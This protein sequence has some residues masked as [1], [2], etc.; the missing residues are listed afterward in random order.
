MEL[1]P[2]Q[3]DAI[4]DLTTAAAHGRRRLLLCAF[5]GSGKT[6]IAASVIKTTVSSGL[7][8]LVLCPRREIVSQTLEKLHNIGVRA[9]MMMSG[10][11]Y[12]PSQ[13]V[14]V[15]SIQTLYSWGI[16]RKRES[17]PKA[18]L[19]VVD[20]CHALSGSE[21]WQRILACYPEAIVVGMSATPI[22]RAGKGLA[23]HFD[24]MICGP[25]CKEL[26][27]QGYLVPVRYYI[28]SIPD[29]R[30]LHV[31]Q[32][33][34]V[35]SELQELMDKPKLVGDVIE[36]WARICPNRQTMI[37]ASGI[38]HSQHLVEG[39]TKI[40]VKAIHIDG[41]TDVKIRDEAIKKFRAKEIQVICN[42]Q[43]Y[44]EGTDLPEIECIAFARP[45]KSLRFFLQ[46]G[47]RGLRTFPGKIDAYVLDF[48]GVLY[49]HGPIDQDWKWELEYNEG[50]ISE[51][52]RKETEK[53][54]KEGITCGSCKAYYEKKLEC[55]F[56]GWV[57]LAKGKPV[58]T[59]EGYLEA[60]SADELPKKE[61]KAIWWQGLA[62]Y[63]NSRGYSS[64]W[65]AHKY[66]KHFGVWPTW[67]V[68][69]L[70]L[71]EP[72]IE[73]KAFIQKEM[74]A[75]VQSKKSQEQAGRPL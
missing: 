31:R 58:K 19:V 6:L 16:K 26:T 54:K 45:T 56:C 65:A 22:S 70:P 53:R 37:F 20:E 36:N 7:N 18:D 40:G 2:Y 27:D 62:H 51:K 66:R 43:V 57:P 68:K 24:E 34:Y 61:D 63:A 17:M 39:F 8:A 12:D 32:G 49:Q 33:D 71:V 41:G 52:M 13:Q 50:S 59:L 1:R 60:L 67:H 9:S 10:D 28:P 73:V 3:V 25:S 15:A 44:A 69:K 47:G 74:N 29:L 35:E 75:Y 55:P 38:K 23:A 64:G 48:A 21:T 14:V 46:A 72:T 5:M 4:D 11:P 42:A 30:K